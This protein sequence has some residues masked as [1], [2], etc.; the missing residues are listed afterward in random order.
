MATYIY[1]FPEELWFNS[2]GSST[3]I[4]NG[5]F[6][7]PKDVEYLLRTHP[8]RVV[9]IERDIVERKE[10]KE[11]SLLGLEDLKFL[12]RDQSDQ[13]KDLIET[14]KSSSSQQVVY[15]QSK[16]GIESFTDKVEKIDIEEP[17]F[18]PYLKHIETENI[19][20]TGNIQDNSVTKKSDVEEKLNKLRK[21]RSKINE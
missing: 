14:I 2:G 3:L 8:D 7:K 18:Q 1:T 4:K 21:L 9:C 10:Y 11:P 6:I 20:V 5:N 16:E 13:I 19:T 17:E 12:V 15:V